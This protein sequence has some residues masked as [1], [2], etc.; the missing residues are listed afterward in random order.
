MGGGLLGP[1]LLPLVFF[2]LLCLPCVFSMERVSLSRPRQVRMPSLIRI[3]VLIL[4]RTIYLRLLPGF[5]N[6]FPFSRE[7]KEKMV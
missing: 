2:K 1:W 6:C 4:V 7:P 3:S 5:A